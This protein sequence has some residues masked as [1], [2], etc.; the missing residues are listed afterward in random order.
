[1][2][3]D[4]ADGDAESVG[5]DGVRRRSAVQWQPAVRR[6]DVQRQEHPRCGEDAGVGGLPTAAASPL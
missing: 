2:V 5:E 1:M 4:E 6:S 3:G